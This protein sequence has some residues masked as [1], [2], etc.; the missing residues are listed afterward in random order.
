[1]PPKINGCSMADLIK[2]AVNKEVVPQLNEMD[3]LMLG[4][5]ATITCLE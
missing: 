3:E 2:L 5:L 4:A 1:M